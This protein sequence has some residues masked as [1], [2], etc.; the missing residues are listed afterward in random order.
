[1]RLG[2]CTYPQIAD[3]VGLS[4]DR[5]RVYVVKV[6][7]AYERMLKCEEYQ[8][9]QQ[10]NS[11]KLKDIFKLIEIEYDHA[12]KCGYIRKP[13]AYALHEVWRKVDRKEKERDG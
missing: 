3:G 8:K 12:Q 1:M 6:Q 4:V 11:D 7:C 10:N 9:R 13:L 2:G 5:A